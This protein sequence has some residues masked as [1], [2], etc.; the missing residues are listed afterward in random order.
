LGYNRLLKKSSCSL[1]CRERDAK[2]FLQTMRI[3]NYF[4]NGDE[5]KFLTPKNQK[6]FL[7]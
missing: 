3:K 6:K 5:V 4:L 7:T 1:I 2:T